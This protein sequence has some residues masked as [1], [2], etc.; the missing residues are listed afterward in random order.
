[1]IR[2]TASQNF[3]Y[4]LRNEDDD[5]ARLGGAFYLEICILFEISEFGRKSEFLFG[6]PNLGIL[7]GRILNMP[8]R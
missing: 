8:L 7:Y 6:R 1:M 2:K 4:T 3:L 5:N